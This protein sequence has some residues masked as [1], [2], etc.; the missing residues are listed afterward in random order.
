MLDIIIKHSGKMENLI[1][2]NETMI[3][4]P[5]V[6]LKEV[7]ELRQSKMNTIHPI[8]LSSQ[9]SSDLFASTSQIVALA[10]FNMQKRNSRNH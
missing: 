10:H 9:N 7:V 5:I 2:I 8:K 1:D 4:H 3:Y 6:M